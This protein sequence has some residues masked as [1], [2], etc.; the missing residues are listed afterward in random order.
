MLTKRKL[1]DDVLYMY[2]YFKVLQFLVVS[3]LPSRIN[4]SFAVCR[5]L[6]GKKN[7][8]HRTTILLLRK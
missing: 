1:L 4:R 7:S 6:P 2:R 5:F 8:C 3:A